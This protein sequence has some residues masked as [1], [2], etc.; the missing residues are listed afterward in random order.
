M[1]PLIALTQEFN[2]QMA[3]LHRVRGQI[4]EAEAT[5]RKAE[6]AYDLAI[7][8]RH[9]GR[10]SQADEEA[11]LGRW[12]AAKREIDRLRRILP[13]LEERVETKRGELAE[14]RRATARAIVAEAEQEIRTLQGQLVDNIEKGKD[15]KRQ[16]ATVEAQ[17]TKKCEELGCPDLRPHVE[18]EATAR[19]HREGLR[20]G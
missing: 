2:E 15:L 11:A 20:E 5:E 3:G 12:T 1:D 7:R 16:I 19:A 13:M 14:A 4:Q 18:F 8:D 9:D 10:R 6:A 17:V